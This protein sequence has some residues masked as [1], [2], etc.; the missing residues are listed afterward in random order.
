M[1]PGGISK[2]S[3]KVQLIN[4][5]CKNL[6]LQQVKVFVF[7]PSEITAKLI[8][9]PMK[10][11]YLILSLLPFL[12]CAFFSDGFVH[13]DE[14]YQILELLNLK[15]SAFHKTEIFNW[16][17]HL[18]MRSW[19]QVFIYF[20]IAKISFVSN[21]FTLAFLFRLLNALLAWLGLYLLV[22]VK[23]L[24]FI[25][26]VWFVPFLLVRTSSEALSTSL[27]LL[28]AFFFQKDG[29]K[30]S[31]FSG[32]LWGMSFLM[33]FQM[34]IPILAVNIWKFVRDRKWKEGLL[35]SLAIVLLV[36]VGVV[37]DRWGYGEWTFTP[38]S[39]LKYN[40]FESRASEFGTSPF[41]YYLTAPI[42]KGGPPLALLLVVGS[43]LYWKQN[44]RGFWSI[45]SLSFLLIHMLIPHKELRFLTFVYILAPYFLSQV[46]LGTGRPW[47]AL[48]GLAI[49]TNVLISCKTLLTPAHSTTN[50]YRY[51]YGD[52]I[53][54]YLTPPQE[55]GSYFKLTM[56]FYEGRS[57]VTR[58]SSSIGP[59][60]YITTT[61]KEYLLFSKSNSCR[62]TFSNYP[63]WVLDQNFF[64][65][66]EH[67][68]ILNVW[69]CEG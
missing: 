43:L 42:V 45:A 21:P 57:V 11:K 12:L 62:N 55:D 15:I 48:W 8:A 32:L 26:W 52:S 38:F 61:Y 25:S 53:P 37:I 67:S 23:R 65:W 44:L 54:V 40:I 68:A 51:V 3:F 50:L 33:R 7:A 41:W 1:P 59:G 14:H 27:F 46:V 58:P 69:N 13:P 9:H 2:K 18:K 63:E 20:L 66:R 29:K 4:Q 49:L 64:R 10:T 19:F 28:G 34:G 60:S 17:F 5:K 36:L 39:Y 56:P 16:D 30:N 47:K 6:D 31:I 35:H 24:A 22:D